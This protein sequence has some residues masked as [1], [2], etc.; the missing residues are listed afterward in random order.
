M[1][2]WR[3]Y[4]ADKRHARTRMS[5]APPRVNHPNNLKVAIRA[6][7]AHNLPK[8]KPT[9]PNF[10]NWYKILTYKFLSP[11]V[12]LAKKI[13]QRISCTVHGNYENINVDI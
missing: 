11:Y 13:F 10:L 9:T 7:I 12:I 3:P 2:F 1:D 8:L 4:G 6:K 5:P